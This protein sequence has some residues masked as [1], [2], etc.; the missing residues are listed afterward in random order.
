MKQNLT[1][2]R[3][4]GVCL[5]KCWAQS[6]HTPAIQHKKIVLGAPSLE[7]IWGFWHFCSCFRATFHSELNHSTTLAKP[8]TVLFYDALCKAL[9]TERYPTVFKFSNH[10][11]WRTLQGILHQQGLILQPLNLASPICQWFQP[12][13]CFSLRTCPSSRGRLAYSAGTC[14]T[15][16]RLMIG[17][18]RNETCHGKLGQTQE[19]ILSDEACSV[20]P[21][22]WAMGTIHSSAGSYFLQSQNVWE[23]I[24]V[25]SWATKDR[26][27]A[28]AVASFAIHI[29]SD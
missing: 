26:I 25:P 19:S 29:L 7:M 12:V 1:N 21:T 14:C 9:K 22:L 11:N 4:A 27:T 2:I 28:A 8:Q 17:L 24:V 18:C 20:H 10:K 3:G 6:P 15:V 16:I 13:Q 5:T 23:R